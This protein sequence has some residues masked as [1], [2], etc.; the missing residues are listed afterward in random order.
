MFVAMRKD[1]ARAQY[2]DDSWQLTKSKALAAVF[3][4]E[5]GAWDAIRSAELT[6]GFPYLAF[7]VVPASSVC[8]V[9][10]PRCEWPE[11]VGG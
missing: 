7:D 8:G 9:S 2:L 6:D 11:V 10:V 3:K 5:A 1:R 4:S